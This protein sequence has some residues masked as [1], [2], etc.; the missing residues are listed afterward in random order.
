MTEMLTD[1]DVRAM[2]ESMLKTKTQRAL[3]DELDVSTA[4][5]NDYLHFRR[6]PG[7]KLLESLGLSRVNMYVRA[8]ATI[9]KDES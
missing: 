2:V 7:P 5:L 3:A 4:Y 8:A 9:A 1:E 6:E